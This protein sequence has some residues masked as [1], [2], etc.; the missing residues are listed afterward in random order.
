[1]TKRVTIDTRLLDLLK[2]KTGDENFDTS[3]IVA[4]ESIAASTRPLKKLNSPYDKAIMA[5]SVLTEAAAILSSTSV[6]LLIMHEGQMLPIGQCL[7]AEVIETDGGHSELRTIFYLEAESPHINKIDLGIID[8]VSVGMLPK[9]AYCSEC[10]FDYLK[11]ENLYNFWMRSCD[12]DHVLGKN[13]V[14]L[15]LIGCDTWSELSL[16]NKG[17]S[18]NAKIVNRAQ[19][20]LSRDTVTRIAA[21]GGN[22][23]LIYLLCSSTEGPQ[24]PNKKSEGTTMDIEKLI[25]D[26]TDAK[27]QCMTLNAS[28]TSLTASKTDLETQLAASQTALAAAQTELTALKAQ[29]SAAELAT[30]KAELTAT[31][32]FLTKN[33]KL[34]LAATGKEIPETAPASAEMIAQL[35][36]AQLQLAAI[37]RGGVSQGLDGGAE[38][39][40]V[41]IQAQAHASAFQS[42]K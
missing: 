14:H 23:E 29:D 9:H 33:W 26:M 42:K 28:V 32:E 39:G 15:R 31:N 6:P 12:N 5:P 17:A 11:P 22:P 27:A 2:A 8:E 38:G 1:M 13:G 30:T 34:A 20:T 24:V 3:K 7:L 37:P 25:A 18:N 40:I 36:A 41:K 16:V 19:Q 21:S 10:E 4:Y 35:E